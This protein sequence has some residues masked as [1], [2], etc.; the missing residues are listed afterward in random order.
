MAR[1]SRLFWS[2][3]QVVGLDDCWEWTASLRHKE[4]KGSYGSFNTG[5]S[6]GL[7]SSSHRVAWELVRGPILKDRLVLHKCDNSIC[8]N[9]LHLFLG[10]QSDNMEDKLNKGRV[11]SGERHSSAK[12]TTLQ[13]TR[14]REDTRSQK[15]IAKE[16]GISQVRV[17][18][19]KLK[20]CWR[21]L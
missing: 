15:C 18:Q 4:D 14:I 21:E 10:S 17:S 11:P 2:K 3:V 12:L 7:S 20:K 16:Y 13:V 19:I 1:I 9:P 5:R 6:Y 8:C